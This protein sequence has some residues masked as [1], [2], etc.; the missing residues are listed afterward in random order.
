MKSLVL[1][2]YFNIQV[3]PT[4]ID[5]RSSV[6]A[7]GLRDAQCQ[8]KSLQMLHKCTKNQKRKGLQ[9]VS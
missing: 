1:L 6:M 4:H 8:L 5:T 9:Q 3:S 7:E 2:F